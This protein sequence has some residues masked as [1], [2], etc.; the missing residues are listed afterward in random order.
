M[1]I[2]ITVRYENK[3]SL[4]DAHS[5]KA[6]KYKET[7]DNIQQRLCCATAEVLP[8]VVGCR[9]AMLRRTVENLNRLGLRNQDMITLVIALR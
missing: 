1:V 9:E 4:A 7:T 5:E 6:R 8:V 3:T 2:D